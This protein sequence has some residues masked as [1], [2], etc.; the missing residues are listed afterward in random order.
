MN[1]KV[2][3][4]EWSDLNRRPITFN[5]IEEFSDFCRQSKIRISG[6]NRFYLK[7]YDTVYAICKKGY[8]KLVLSGNN[9]Q[10]RKNFHKH[11]NM[12]VNA[13]KQQ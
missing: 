10:L 4:Y 5:S 12:K 3:F 9:F 13:Q 6:S 7:A 8:P 11:N 1:T 2:L